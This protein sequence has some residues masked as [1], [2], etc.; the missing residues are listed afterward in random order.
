MAP[1]T[2]RDQ[3]LL[4]SQDGGV[5]VAH[6]NRPHAHNALSATLVDSLADL[7]AS[8]CATPSVVPGARCLV[9]T[10]AHPSFCSGIDVREP[11][12]HEPAA[13]LRRR[14]AFRELIS[15]LHRVPFPTIAGV[16]G[17]VLGA[18][19]EVALACDIVVAGDTAKFGLPELAVGAVP[20]GGGVHALVQRAGRG[21][22]AHM[23]LAGTRVDAARMA[24][25]GAIEEVVPSGEAGARATA[26]G[27]RFAVADPDALRGCVNLIRNAAHLSRPDALSVEDGYWWAGVGARV[28]G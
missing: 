8:L 3:P 2:M 27:A 10:G 26:I 22:A 25:T 7:V 11:A 15:S 16:E 4:V 24:H 21:L 20:G 6:L 28:P 18:G 14:G 23:L 1:V 5:V 12:W 13:R 9:L 19:L 17:H